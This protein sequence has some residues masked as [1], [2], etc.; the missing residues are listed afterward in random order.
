MARFAASWQVTGFALVATFV[1]GAQ[2]SPSP[3]T[4]SQKTPAAS[5]PVSAQA[6]L[7]EAQKARLVLDR[8]GFGARPGEVEKV[9]AM[10]AMNWIDRQLQPESIRDDALSPHLRGL[11]VPKMSTAEL[12]RKYPNPTALLRQVERASGD[13][14]RRDD[15]SAMPDAEP[16]RGER[17]QALAKAYREMGGE[18]PREVYLQLAADRLLRATYSE[19]QLQ[20]T[21]VD[22]WSNHFNVY[23]RKNVSQWF[24]PAFDREVIRP[25]ALGK[26][27]DLLL[28]SAQS[29]AMLFYLDNYE[30]VS[31]NADLAG[32]ADGARRDLSKLSD[33]QLR[34]ALTK[35]RGLSAAEADERI[36]RLR[37]NPDRSLAQRLPDG[38]NENY[39]RE[40][41]ELHTL[42]VDG[43][44]SQQDIREVAR[45][46]T[47]WTI[48]DPRGYRQYAGASGDDRLSRQLR[49]QSERFGVPPD[50]ESGTFY[51]NAKLHD[52][53]TKTVLGQR[54]DDGGMEDGREVID[55]LAR[56]PSTARFLANKLAV[57]FVSDEPP[58]AWS[59]AS[60]RRSRAATATSAKPCAPCSTIRNSSHR[61]TTGRRSRRRSNWSPA[62]CVPCRPKPTGAKC[63]RC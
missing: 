23:A 40:L 8:L 58:P 45:C 59:I 38:I 28:A 34:V 18:R 42:G 37:G 7:T 46:L 1:V 3:A 26:F 14:R 13:R 31:P 54:I 19:K 10:G 32:K 16:D 15:T 56:H 36:A 2:A 49:R 12:Y 21:M 55:L 47:G 43:G 51:F 24:L 44:Y 6:P 39:A 62:A 17:R 52:P 61:S 22:F 60:P 11:T 29:P 50:G 57:K 41:M 9:E 5:M 30:S 20:E 53:G 35:R 4:M 48:L 63:K 27:R 25:H 33:E